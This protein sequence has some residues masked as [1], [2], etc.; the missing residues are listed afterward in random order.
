MSTLIIAVSRTSGDASRSA[1]NTNRMGYCHPT[2]GSSPTALSL[3]CGCD[4][5]GGGE[6]GHA[7]VTHGAQRDELAHALH[8]QLQEVVEHALGV[9]A[10]QWWTPQ[11]HPLTVVQRER[12]AGVVVRPDRWMVE[13]HEESAGR[14]RAVRG[15]VVPGDRPRDRYPR[16]S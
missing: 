9:L 11:R 8:V 2:A 13:R 1:A 12:E 15:H 7:S 10:Q 14:I 4:R 5:G 6:R 3:T 16:A